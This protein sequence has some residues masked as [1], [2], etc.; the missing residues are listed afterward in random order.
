[1]ELS[2][3]NKIMFLLLFNYVQVMVRGT[4]SSILDRPCD[5]IISIFYHILG[6]PLGYT[7]A[8]D[9]NVSLDNVSGCQSGSDCPMGTECMFS[10]ISPVYLCCKLDSMATTTDLPVYAFASTYQMDA[11]IAA[12]S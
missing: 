1:M 11:V 4:N 9:L 12:Q 5:G 7:S 8:Y 10:P 2:V 6:C 3:K